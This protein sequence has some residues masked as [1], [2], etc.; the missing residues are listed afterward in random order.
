MNLMIPLLTNVFVTM[1]LKIIISYFRAPFFI[2]QRATRTAG[3]AIILENYNLNNLIN[4]LRLY[5]YTINFADNSIICLST[6]AF[7]KDT[8]RFSV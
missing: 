8:R 7:T 4:N 6:I 5:L 1:V 2:I 3:V